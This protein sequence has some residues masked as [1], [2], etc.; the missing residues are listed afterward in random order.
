MVSKNKLNMTP[1]ATR[2]TQDQMTAELLASGQ[3]IQPMQP[4]QPSPVDNIIEGLGQGAKGLLQGFGDFINSQKDTPEG[5][6]LLNNMLAGVTVALGADPMLG[7]NIVKQGQEQFKLGLSKQEKESQREFELE[8]LGLKQR[9]EAEK[10]EREAAE[11]KKKQITKLEDDYRKEYNTKKIV[12]DSKE[13]DSAISR[14]DNVW[15]KYQSNPNPNSK[16]A[17]DQ[18][19]VI[20]FN[21]MLDPGSVVRESEF[22]RTP[23]GQNLISRIQG[24]SEKLAQGGVGLT[25]AERDE[26][27]VVAKQLQE[28]QMIELE[29]EKQL[30]RELAEQR[31]L[32]IENIL[33][34]NKTK[35]PEIPKGIKSITDSKKTT[36]VI[37]LESGFS[38][39]VLPDA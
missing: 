10:A 17:L 19:L 20:T 25:D 2:P 12:K 9:A 22:A 23:Q 24:A 37:N 21:K 39:E 1:M 5:R 15:N 6:L 32:N 4:Q 38:M 30:Y 36:P 8:K 18:A 28:G 33:G 31:G 26:I 29:K 27:I 7:A 11:E 16:N 3:P 14:M 13:I 35:V 34:K